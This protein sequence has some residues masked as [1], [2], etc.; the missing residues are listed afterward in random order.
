MPTNEID[1]RS[2]VDITRAIRDG[3]KVFLRYKAEYVNEGRRVLTVRTYHDHVRVK[4]MPKGTLEAKWVI[5]RDGDTSPDMFVEHPTDLPTEYKLIP[6]G[7]IPGWDCFAPS[8]DRGDRHFVGPFTAEVS[9]DCKT[10]CITVNYKTH[11]YYPKP[12]E[13][14]FSPKRPSW[15]Q[16]SC[17][18]RFVRAFFPWTDKPD[19]EFYAYGTQDSLDHLRQAWVAN[20]GVAGG[21]EM[22]NPDVRFRMKLIL[23]NNDLAR[24]TAYDLIRNLNI[25]TSKI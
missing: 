14:S 4:V 3:R 2:V 5:L 16:S 19:F 6:F 13:S 23:P 18:L 8:F 9:E 24:N 22:Y 15:H 11:F 21:V 17:T 20:T 10:K 25:P 7:P 12:G 1:Q